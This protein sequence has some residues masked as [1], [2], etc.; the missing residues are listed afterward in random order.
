MFAF[1]GKTG[2]VE[3]IWRV[4]HKVIPISQ[5][6][7]NFKQVMRELAVVTSDKEIFKNILALGALSKKSMNY[8]LYNYSDQFDDDGLDGGLGDARFVM[9]NL[10]TFIDKNIHIDAK[11]GELYWK[12]ITKMRP[13]YPVTDEEIAQGVIQCVEFALGDDDEIIVY[14]TEKGLKRYICKRFRINAE[15]KE[16]PQAKTK[17]SKKSQVKKVKYGKKKN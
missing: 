9:F 1:N 6:R 8:V 10:K 13:I 3:E 11:N 17:K 2:S 14:F 12:E 5:V 16:T 15:K 4:E 7:N